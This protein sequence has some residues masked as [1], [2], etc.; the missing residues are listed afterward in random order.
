M[1]MTP[2]EKQNFAEDFQEIRSAYS[3]VTKNDKSENSRALWA[4]VYQLNMT[5]RYLGYI[6]QELDMTNKA[7]RGFSDLMKGQTEEFQKR[8]QEAQKNAPKDNEDFQ[9]GFEESFKKAQEEAIK[10][11]TPEQ[12]K[13][14]VKEYREIADKIENTEKDDLKERAAASNLHPIDSNT[15]EGEETEDGD[16]DTYT[17]EFPEK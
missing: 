14:L 1:A 13:E 17:V 15:V 8:M 3:S 5:C 2:M 12:R 9:K 10:Q 11:M 7:Q 4:M 6:V 16:V